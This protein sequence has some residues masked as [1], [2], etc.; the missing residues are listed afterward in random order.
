MENEKVDLFTQVLGAYNLK[1]CILLKDSSNIKETDGRFR[2]QLYENYRYDDIPELIKRR[3]GPEHILRICDNFGM[4]TYLLWLP[5]DFIMDFETN[6]MTIGPFLQSQPDLYEIQKLMFREKLPD[7]L[8]NDIRTH[9]AKLPVLGE[10]RSFEHFL[11]S[12]LKNFFGISYQFFCFPEQDEVNAENSPTYHKL[13]KAP[14]LAEFNLEEHYK[15]ENLMLSAVTAGDY[16]NARMYYDTFMTFH[17]LPRT[18]NL[19]NNNRNFKIILNTLLRKAAEAGNVHPLYID[20]IS[21]KFA[22][23]INEAKSMNELDNLS[24]DMIHKYCLLVQN[25]SMKSFSPV[26]QT[27]VSYIDFHYDEDLSLNFFTEMCHLTKTY[28]SNLFKKETGTTLTDYIHTVRMRKALTFLNGTSL[29]IQTI[30]SVCGYS[31][32]N[33]F[34]RIF[35]RRYGL[36]P[37]QYQK[38]IVTK[39]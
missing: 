12:L 29:S 3:L 36:S 18:D 19:L 14:K 6:V 30:A 21:T 22:V 26:I 7:E 39:K 9:Y 34:I 2:Y 13:R 5:D 23:L 38:S 37:K 11:L 35:K 15:L 16:Q 4:Y 27:I 24:D 10:L 20:D 31:D 25:H 17:L 28:L 1:T 32:L 8:L 33:Y